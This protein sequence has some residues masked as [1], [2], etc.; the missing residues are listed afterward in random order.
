[1]KGKVKIIMAITFAKG[2]NVLIQQKVGNVN[3]P[4]YPYTKF[5]NVQDSENN[6]L[7]TVIAN[8]KATQ[9][10]AFSA[11]A[12]ENTFLADDGVF[13]AI[14]AASTTQAGVVQLSSA[15]DST[16]E[17]VA[18][19]A[20]AV[21]SAY[22]KAAT[23]ETALGD[24]VTTS[25]FNA[26]KGAANGLATLNESG[27]VTAS[28]LPSYVDDVIVVDMAN[29][30]LSATNHETSAAVTPD[31]NTI[32]MDHATNKIY[33]WSGSIF[34]V[35]PDSLAIGTTAGTAYDGAAG[36]ALAQTVANGFA[37]YVHDVAAGDTNGTIKF[38][39]GDNENFT[40]V[41]VF[42][43]DYPTKASLGLDQV[44]NMDGATI[45]STYLT[46]A[47]IDTAYSVPAGENLA[48]DHVV[49]TASGDK[50]LMTAA[51]L[52]DLQNTMAMAV[53]TTAPSFENGLWLQVVSEDE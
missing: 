25:D 51:M 36:A 12:T 29:D 13:R 53:S 33:R 1:M 44:E 27:K 34:V 22:D 10:P 46:K 47:A 6:S 16:S 18:A 52:T 5:D 23:V 15:V 38:K 26:L 3:T 4:I 37:A 28:Q 43:P 30:F 14:Q 17:T 24:Y 48:T 21:K 41:T 42:T 39:V 8:L 40:T 9:V 31:S 20:S 35:I 50:G 2:Y 11:T 19:T 49:T 32:Y 7:T 45:I